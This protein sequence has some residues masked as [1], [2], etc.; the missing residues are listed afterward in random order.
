MA[1]KLKHSDTFSAY[2]ITF[3]CIEWIPLFDITQA[4][5][6]VYKWF[7]VLR[8]EYNA[9]VVA[10]VIMPN[11]LHVIV[12]FQKEGFNLNT[13]IS[14]GKRMMAYQMIDRLEK[15]GST[16]MLSRLQ[17]LVTDR[18]KKKG[19]L[20]KVFTESFDAKAIFSHKFLLQKINYIHNNPVSGKWM[21]AKDFVEYEHSSA[22]FYE[23]QLVRRF[24]PMHYIDL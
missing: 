13:I 7:A 2:F 18:E 17:N 12:H 23:I 22:S 8:E 9:D 5:D 3:T 14:N 15:A 19:Q 24:K 1:I 4:Y 10:Y 16:E 21:L 6:L 11:H 20:H